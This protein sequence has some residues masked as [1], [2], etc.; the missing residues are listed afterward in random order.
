VH[1]SEGTAGATWQIGLNL[2]FLRLTRVHNPNGISIG[3]AVFAQLTTENPYTLYF[4]MGAPFPQNCPFLWV[5]L[6]PHVIYDSV[7]PSKPITQTA[8][9]SLQPF[10]G[11]TDQYNTQT[12]RQTDRP[13]YLVGN[14][15]TGV[16]QCSLLFR[17]LAVLDPRVGHTMDV[18][19]RFISIIC[20]FD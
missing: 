8:C 13:R 15:S 1:S 18:L 2:C 10:L 7:G 17:S 11:L 19:S 9:R 20:H 4:T 6:D 5:D 14:N 16:L 3:S 12:D